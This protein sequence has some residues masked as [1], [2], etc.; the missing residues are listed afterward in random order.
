MKPGSKTWL[1]IGALILI[2]SPLI[3]GGTTYIPITGLRLLIL[4]GTAA[5]L[6]Q[7]LKD[8]SFAVAS[9]RGDLWILAFWALTAL[10][11]VRSS[12][13]YMTAYW[14][15][16]IF[17]LILLYYLA[18][19]PATLNQPE[20]DRIYHGTATL[21]LLMAVAFSLW[22]IAEFIFGRESRASAGFFNPNGLAGYLLAISP[23]ALARLLWPIDAG[24]AADPSRARRF[25]WQRLSLL[26]ALL[27]MLAAI[28]CTRSRAVV[29][30]FLSFGALLCLR[31][32][33]KALVPLAAALVL[34]VAV[35]N[36]VRERMLTLRQGDPYAWERLRIWEA[37][38][39]MIRDHPAGVG[40]GLYKYYYPRYG[41]AVETI[42]VGRYEKSAGTAHSELLHLAAELS[43]LAP[44]LLLGIAVPLILLT[45]SFGAR[46]TW[47]LGAR[48]T[49]SLGARVPSPAHAQPDALG[50]AAGLLA[51]TAHGIIDANLHETAIAVAAVV[52][53]AM[54]TAWLGPGSRGGTRR[55]RFSFHYPW[56]M[57][58]LLL[59]LTPVIAAAL[60][61]ISAAYGLTEAYARIPDLDE[62]IQ[63]LAR[64]APYNAGYA[65]LSDHLSQAL[66]QKARLLGRVE[67]LEKA[68]REED[69]A[70]RRNPNNYRYAQGLGVLYLELAKLLK[71]DSG[72]LKAAEH[73]FRGALTLY[74]NHPFILHRLAEISRRRG[75]WPEEEGWLREA[76]V[77]EP[78]YFQ[79][80]VEL[81]IGLARQG[82]LAAAGTQFQ[83]LASQRNEIRDMV[84]KQPEAFATPYQRE[85]LYLPAGQ[86]EALAKQ[87]EPK[88]GP[89][90]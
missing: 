20:R 45:F 21:L 38:L 70:R 27:L 49:W 59:T 3:E 2:G 37:S 60:V 55:R 39:E 32:R 15:G 56:V 78:F 80:R 25:N 71:K 77:R 34:L 44:L 43:P 82:D 73:Y 76:L 6:W 79:A 22:G 69:L 61:F 12:Y 19:Q 46:G 88:P 68:I 65:P 11:L 1:V 8:P 51:V 28:L 50:A 87:F 23:F 74:P 85:L 86:W 26:A 67:L 40:L 72:L 5:W 57:K 7:G 75:Q 4:A 10:S 48:G 18:L 17:F 81:I 90:P 53:A 42:K 24:G 62:R 36:P 14:Y 41:R 84:K 13:P 52:L 35:P 16:N 58:A 30:G 31:F 54:L 83:I 29:I 47:S 64:I 63:K 33:L 89:T 9:S 66:F